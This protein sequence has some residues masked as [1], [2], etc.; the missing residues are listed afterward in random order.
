MNLPG[1]T[2]LRVS[3]SAGVAQVVLDNPPVNALSATMM[4]ELHD[5]LGLLREETSVRVI[6]FSSANDEFFLAHVDMHI[7]EHMDQLQEVAAKFPDVNVHQ[8]IGELL[9]HQPQ[10]SIVKLAGLARAG[11][12]EFVIAADMAFAA[13][14]T[15]GIGQTEALL[16]II[17]GGGGTQ[18]LGERV[19]R[20]RALELVLSG[21]LLD[22]DTAAAYGW[23]NRAV[24]AADLDTFVDTLAANIAAV[25]P[26][27][28]AQAKRVLPPSDLIAGLREEHDAWSALVSGESSAKLMASALANGI[29]TPQAERDVESFLRN[30]AA[31]L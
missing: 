11:G 5:L 1:Y 15:S 26:E 22:A 14:E 28:I 20:N 6:V 27:I 16:G 3:I 31:T 13:K 19:G 21:D 18:Y 8:G 9:R 4:V 12:A 25:G 17:P 7:F 29:Q 10:V 24:P 2:T 23:I 30:V